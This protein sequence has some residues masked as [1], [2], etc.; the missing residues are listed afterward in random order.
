MSLASAYSMPMFWKISIG[1]VYYSV[2][3]DLRGCTQK[4]IWLKILKE[5]Y[6][7][8]IDNGKKEILVFVL[9]CFL[10]NKRL[11]RLHLLLL[12]KSIEYKEYWRVNKYECQL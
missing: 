9:Y 5:G 12:E 3:V 4:L 11:E 6:L 2:D 7:K 10:K 8:A 1:F